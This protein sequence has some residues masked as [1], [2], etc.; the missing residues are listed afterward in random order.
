MKLLSFYR[1]S[2][3]TAILFFLLAIVWLFAPTQLL[4]VW[5]LELTI[6]AGLVGRRAS[7]LYAGIAVM[8]YMAR[9]AEHSTARTALIYGM[10]TSC[11]I[12]AFLGVYEFCIGHASSGILAAVLIE[13]ILVLAFLF[14]GCPCSKKQIVRLS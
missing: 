12:L 7:A 4:S 11:L 9:N 14:I 1:L 2:V 8:F 6:A 13:V 3:I 10:I 5:G